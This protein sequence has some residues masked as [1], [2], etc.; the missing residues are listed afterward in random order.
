MDFLGQNLWLVW[1]FVGLLLVIV[2]AVLL[3][4]RFVMLAAGAL[5]GAL[6]AALGASLLVQAL[7]AAVIAS[8]LVLLVR[9]RVLAARDE[10][11][12]RRPR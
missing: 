4:F 12:P 7:V 3:D 10:G 9:P 6:A 1:M 11:G 5:C 8:L 2:E